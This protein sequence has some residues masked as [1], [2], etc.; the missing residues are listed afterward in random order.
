MGHLVTNGTHLAHNH[1]HPKGE[2]ED[3]TLP[4][5]KLKK[6]HSQPKQSPHPNGGG[7]QFNKISSATMT[8]YP[9]HASLSHLA[10]CF[11]VHLCVHGN[12]VEI[13]VL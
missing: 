10:E 4:N 13:Q 5:D 9:Y 3:L 8:F 2:K 12:T 1:T 11:Q 6:S 7:K